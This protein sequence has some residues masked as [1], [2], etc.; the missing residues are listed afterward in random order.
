MSS[1]QHAI[2]LFHENGYKPYDIVKAL[3]KLS[4]SESQVYLVCKRLNA[5]QSIDNRHQSGRRRTIRTVAAIRRV[6]PAKTRTVS[7]KDFRSEQDVTE[8]HSKNSQRRLGTT[9]L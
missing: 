2:K 4:V 8:I 5:G 3:K 9:S 6:N 1:K 7:K